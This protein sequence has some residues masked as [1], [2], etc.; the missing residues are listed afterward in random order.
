LSRLFAKPS[1]AG[2]P[3]ALAAVLHRLH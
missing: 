1:I 3:T 2:M